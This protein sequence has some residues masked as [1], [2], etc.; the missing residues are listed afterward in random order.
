MQEADGK[1][2]VLTAVAMSVATLMIA[3]H[4]AGKATRDALFLTYFDIA[5][6]PKVMM[7]SA[8]TK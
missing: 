2:G 6:L 3:Q 7:V 4:I 1:T 8:R 5:Q